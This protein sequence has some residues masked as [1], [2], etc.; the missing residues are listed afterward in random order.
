MGG[1]NRPFSRSGRP[2]QPAT[3]TAPLIAITL[4]CACAAPK[5]TA[6]QAP[7]PPNN[8]QSRAVC[9]ARCEETR[10]ECAN[11]DTEAGDL[12]VEQQDQCNA[13]S[14]RCVARCRGERPPQDSNGVL[15]RPGRG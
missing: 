11:I 15:V 8:E 10:G 4:L 12:W 6:P 13:G 3:T 9:E 5:A 1:P 14:A 7:S 2:D